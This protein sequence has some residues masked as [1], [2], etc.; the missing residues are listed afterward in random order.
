MTTTKVIEATTSGT[1]IEKKV[2]TFV[3]SNGKETVIYEKILTWEVFEKPDTRDGNF[4][5]AFHIEKTDE[6]DQDFIVDMEPNFIYSK[7]DGIDILQRMRPE[8]TELS[9]EKIAVVELFLPNIEAICADLYDELED[10]S[11]EDFQAEK[12]EPDYYM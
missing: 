5:I 10:T 6:D 9:D 11:Y 8:M 2:T 12:G 4:K 3:D 1:Q 7:S